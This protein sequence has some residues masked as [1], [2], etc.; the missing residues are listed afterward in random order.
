RK[1]Q[2]API[3]PATRTPSWRKTKS[4]RLMAASGEGARRTAHRAVHRRKLKLDFQTWTIVLHFEVCK[5]QPSDDS[6]KAETEAIARG[7]SAALDPVEPLEDVL[8]LLKGNARPT[9]SD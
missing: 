4:N 9:I 8:A 5:M 3:R 1:Q 2:K 6:D 7:G